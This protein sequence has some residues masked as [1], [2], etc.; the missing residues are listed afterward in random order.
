MYDTNHDN[1]LNKS[2]WSNMKKD[3]SSADTDGDGRI[4]PLELA[5]HMSKL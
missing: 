2:E 3:Y 4:T 1:V 5:E